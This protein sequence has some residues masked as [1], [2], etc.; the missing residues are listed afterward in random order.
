MRLHPQR[1]TQSLGTNCTAA[2]D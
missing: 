2:D 1:Q